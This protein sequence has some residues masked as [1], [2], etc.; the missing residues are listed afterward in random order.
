MIFNELH[1]IAEYLPFSFPGIY[2]SVKFDIYDQ[3]NLIDTAS[4]PVIKEKEKLNFNYK[5]KNH[6]DFTVKNIKF[7]LRDIFGFTEF[8]YKIRS[9]FKITVYPYYND[10]IKV[11]F[12]NNKDG[13]EVLQSVIRINS[14]DFFEN[15]K[16]YPGDDPRKIN[17]KIFAHIKELHVRE[18]E[19]IPPKI[20]QIYIIFAPY[21][22]IAIEFEYISSLFVTTADF[23]LKFG[24]EL[25]ILSPLS[26]NELIINKTNESEFNIIINSSFKQIDITAKKSIENVIFFGSF[27]EYSR[28]IESNIIKNSFAAVTFFSDDNIRIY[29][30]SFLL[31]INKYDSLIK[32]FIEKIKINNQLKK[33][34]NLLE[35]ITGLSETNK[36][37]LE[38]YKTGNE[39]ETKSNT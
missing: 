12:F 18:I 17:W 14:T 10:N 4:I 37:K 36:V 22:D 30:S 39:F 34:Y 26:N 2:Y 35:K 38:I 24:V 23:L 13:S 25:K 1:I 11:P 6:G 3:N 9:N 29:D 15:R 8:S 21:S 31:K 28:I 19:K 27:Y 5:F 7:I 16:Y 32:D 20:G 33:R